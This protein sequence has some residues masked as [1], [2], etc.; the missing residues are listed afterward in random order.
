MSRRNTLPVTNA[1]NWK[2]RWPV[3]LQRNA[4]GAWIG[5]T[6]FGA[7]FRRGGIDQQ[8]IQ[9]PQ[10]EATATRPCGTYW[11]RS[12]ICAGILSGCSRHAAGVKNGHVDEDEGESDHGDGCDPSDDIQCARIHEVAHQVA[13]V[14]EQQH[15]NEDDGKPDPVAHL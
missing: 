11:V 2:W 14:D 8:E 7:G 4:I 13:A 6:H 10:A 15:E 12:R 1:V 5:D 9:T 3:L